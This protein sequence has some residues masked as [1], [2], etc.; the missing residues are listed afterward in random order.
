MVLLF[1]LVVVVIVG[2]MAAIMIVAVGALGGD[3]EI[4]DE[5]GWP[6]Q[7]SLNPAAEETY[8]PRW[9]AYTGELPFGFAT[10]GVGEYH[11][12]TNQ[13]VPQGFWDTYEF[14]LQA[15]PSGEIINSTWDDP[16]KHPDFAWVPY[17]NTA[18]SGSSENPYLQWLNLLDYL[19]DDVVRE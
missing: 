18:R 12:D 2:L 16:E 6:R 15:S 3:S 1:V 17:A 13:E 9:H 5:A 4:D 14:T 11:V 8:H 10:D 7:A 19:G